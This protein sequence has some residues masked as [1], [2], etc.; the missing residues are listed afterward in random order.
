MTHSAC[1]SAKNYFESKSQAERASLWLKELKIHKLGK[2]TQAE[3]EQVC[4]T[5]EDSGWTA[6]RGYIT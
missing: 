2:W 5:D 1:K 6:Q 3:R 4:E